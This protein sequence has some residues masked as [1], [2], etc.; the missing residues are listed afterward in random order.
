MRADADKIAIAE[1]ASLGMVGRV[2]AL[3]RRMSALPS[4][5]TITTH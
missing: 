3:Y 1:L 5:V 4:T 2:S